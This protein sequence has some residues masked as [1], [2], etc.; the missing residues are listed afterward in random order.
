MAVGTSIPVIHKI[1]IPST[2]DRHLL[3]LSRKFMCGKISLSYFA[4][5]KTYVKYYFSFVLTFDC[6]HSTLFRNS[7]FPKYIGI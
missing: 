1:F 4:A 6:R 2:N 5:L 7:D 3:E